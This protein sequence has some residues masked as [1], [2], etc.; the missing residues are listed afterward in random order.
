MKSLLRNSIF[1][2][3]SAC[4]AS[5]CNEQ[6]TYHSYQS[7]PKEGWSKS[8]TLFFEVTL[9]DSLASHWQL[10]AEVR[11]E[12][13]YPYQDLYLMISY[14]LPDTLV[15]KTDTIKF[16]LADKEGKWTGRGWGGLFQSTVPGH[17]V[18]SRQPGKYTFKVTHAMKDSVL[19]GLNNVGI[20]LE[21]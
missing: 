19:K 18:S 17:L 6:T 3:L 15:W 9:P 20:R 5:A 12:S 16:I 13:S 8:D 4:L 21:K 7:L 2:V 10:Y 1:C 14:N 11:N